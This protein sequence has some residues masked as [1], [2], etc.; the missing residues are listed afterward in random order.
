MVTNLSSFPSAL[1][2]IPIPDG[3]VRKHR[4]AF[5]VNEDLKRLGCSGRSGL[6]LTDA[7][8]ATRAKFFQLYKVSDRIQFAQ[9]VVELVKLCQIALYMFEKLEQEYV[10]G[11][12][13]DVTENAINNWWTEVGSEHYNFEP[14]DGILGPSTVAALLG[15]FMG[16]RNRLN[17]YGA[18]VPKDVF[19]LESMRR[20]LWYFQR[21]QKLEKTRR[22]DRQTLFRLHTATAKAAAGEGWRAQKAVKSAMTEIGGKRGEIVMDMVSG[23]EKAGL[24]DIETLDIAVFAKLVYGDRPKWLWQGKPRRTPFDYV[25]VDPEHSHPAPIKTDPQT[26]AGR[27][28]EEIPPSRRA[29]D[30][31]GSYQG[32]GQGYATV[33]GYVDKDGSRRTVFKSVAGR[34]NDARSGL[35]RIKGAVGG[36]RKGHSSQG[37]M[38]A[39]DPFDLT[40]PTGTDYADAPHSN[41]AATGP[42]A[43]GRAFTWKNKPDAY[44][45]AIRRGDGDVFQDLSD[46]SPGSQSTVPSTRGSRKTPE[47]TLK[48]R[49]ASE[50]MKNI[51]TDVRE[52]VLSRAPSM[53]RSAA[54]EG[55]FEGPFLQSE[56]QTF[57]SRTALLRRHSYGMFEVGLEHA[58]NENRWARRMSFG[59][60][61]EAVLPWE[62]IISENSTSLDQGDGTARLEVFSRQIE[63]IV[64][65]LEPWVE[66]KIKLVRKLDVRYGQDV[67]E[68]RMLYQQLNE[69]CLRVRDNS[70]GMLSDER[71]GLTES[72]KGIEVLVARLEYEINALIA[73]VNDV[74]DGIRNYE[75]Q[76]DDVEERADE[77]KRQ[78]ETESWL[79]WFVRTLTGIGTGPNITRITPER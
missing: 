29:D 55:D 75:R 6:T 71:D 41:G 73:R 44:L 20:G 21:T 4:Q 14:S 64:F 48:Q 11:L 33:D 42:A 15:M 67:T 68:L 52:E 49:E 26:L 57:P 36:G 77:L 18:P 40:S 39:K 72:I 28:S 56:R 10:D 46:D 78:L 31:A 17:W 16:A 27:Q 53:T 34:M 70:N 65:G 59:D 24:A 9:S 60:A 43:V 23:K 35:G 37:S 51:G 32:Q 47:A 45:N 50:K 69:A 38:S 5:F 58:P 79:H 62:D 22:L 12:L 30:M 7:T 2:V 19:D 74:E 1:T 13:C 63:Q 66:D 3:D 76:V 61:E 54:D 8:E 25:D